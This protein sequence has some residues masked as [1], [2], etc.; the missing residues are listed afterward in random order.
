MIRASVVALSLCMSLPASAFDLNGVL[1]SGQNALK[2]VNL[3][4]ADVQELS[5]RAC[6]R[7]D[8]S[9]RVAGPQSTYAKRLAT[10][11]QAMP[12][13]IG[14]RTIDSKVYMSDTVNAWAMANGCVRIYSGLMDLMNDAELRGV[15][16]HEEG[17]VALGH[18]RRALQT[19]YA[20]A[21]ARG[22]AGAAGGGVAAVSRSGIGDFAE[23]LVHAQFSQ[24]QELAADDY[25]FDLLT[26]RRLDREAL[27]TAFQK[28]A[29][30]DGGKSSMLS[31]HPAAAERAKA[32]QRRIDGT[33]NAS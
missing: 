16:G 26:Q 15:I 22:L 8:G 24:S 18:T 28:L 31:S 11:M 9:S 13:R 20:A 4:D 3:S 7:M 27:V 32:I 23:K 2:A 33:K 12:T 17:H 14:A 10:L 21:A 29:K 30:L 19:A 5:D 6:A 25:S 1:G